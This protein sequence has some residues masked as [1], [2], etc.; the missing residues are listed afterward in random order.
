MNQSGA[1][2][3]GGC[4]K[5][6]VNLDMSQHFFQFSLPDDS[7]KYKTCQGGMTTLVFGLFF[8]AFVITELLDVYH[9]RSTTVLQSM[10][11]NE[12][13]HHVF[14]FGNEQGF[15]VAA[16]IVDSDSKPIGAE[17][18]KIKF[19]M[20]SWTQSLQAPDFKTL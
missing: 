18:G 13:S 8:I 5:Q 11:R 3:R 16:T 17:I 7:L 12:F 19:V 14:E 1:Q 2:R 20:K 4:R 9:H 10:D 15:A 6:I